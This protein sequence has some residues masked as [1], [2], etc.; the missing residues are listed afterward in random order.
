MYNI[1][2]LE[3]YDD[4]SGYERDMGQHCLACSLNSPKQTQRA[5]SCQWMQMKA[6]SKSGHY[7][8]SNQDLPNYCSRLF[9]VCASKTSLSPSPASERLLPY[10]QSASFL[11]SPI[12]PCGHARNRAPAPPS[13]P[14][15]KAETSH[16]QAPQTFQETDRCLLSGSLT[17]SPSFSLPFNLQVFL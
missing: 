5:I 6:I 4:T 3:N 10:F 17:P 13:L 14:S 12:W 11:R 7:L 16:S 2:F 9:S 1:F 15:R 8:V